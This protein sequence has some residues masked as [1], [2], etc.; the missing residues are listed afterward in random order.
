MESCELGVYIE[1]SNEGQKLGPGN[2][3]FGLHPKL[4]NGHTQ[5]KSCRHVRS[6]WSTAFATSAGRGIGSPRQV[7]PTSCMRHCYVSCQVQ[8]S[9]TTESIEVLPCF[10]PSSEIL[11]SQ[12]LKTSGVHTMVCNSFFVTYGSILQYI[13]TH[14]FCTH[15]AKSL[16]EECIR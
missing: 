3:G 16:I 4:Q 10:H 13:L 5:L 2:L 15:A 14:Q 11:T 9:E 12:K 8:V 6:S 1:N 7:R